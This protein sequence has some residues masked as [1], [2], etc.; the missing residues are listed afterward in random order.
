MI[1]YL[2]PTTF[3]LGDPPML[4]VDPQS[5]T[6]TRT[7]RASRSPT[8]D[9]KAIIN[10]GGY[11]EADRTISLSLRNL[12]QDQADTLAEIAAYPACTLALD[13]G[14]FEGVVIDHQFAAPNRA[15]FTFWV[16]RR[17]Y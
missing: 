11:S 3:W 17:L 12:T 16:T 2:T 10:D 1:A 5:D 8:L 15:R 9:G 13:H 7:R 14:L 4:Q 6:R